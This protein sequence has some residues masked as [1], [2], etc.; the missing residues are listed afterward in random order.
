[1]FTTSHS[2]PRFPIVYNN[3]R[4]LVPLV[5]EFAMSV[6]LETSVELRAMIVVV[7]V[8]L[9]IVVVVSTSVALPLTLHIPPKHVLIRHKNDPDISEYEM[10]GELKAKAKRSG[11]SIK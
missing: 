2:M 3:C 8:P 7:S 9:T 10:R 4:L 1:M 11:I 5:V 6:E